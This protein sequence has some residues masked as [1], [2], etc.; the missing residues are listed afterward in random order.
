M[1]PTQMW[2]CPL[3]PPLVPPSAQMGPSI[4]VLLLH[5]P[6]LSVLLNLCLAICTDW[7]SV[8]TILI[9]FHYS[10]ASICPTLEWTAQPTGRLSLSL[11][12][13]HTFSCSLY[14]CIW[15]WLIAQGIVKWHWSFSLV[16]A[17][18]ILIHSLTLTQLHTRTFHSITSIGQFNCR[19]QTS[20]GHL[21]TLSLLGR[22]IN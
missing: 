6:A 19:A 7:A 3:H 17:K 11:S 21:A 4:Q 10:G 20:I 9:A 13:T 14:F 1:L 18:Q 16:Q 12:Q 5:S 2:A 8:I 22:Q 15:A